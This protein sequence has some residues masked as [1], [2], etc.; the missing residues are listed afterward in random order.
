MHD[1]GLAGLRRC[2]GADDGVG[3]CKPEAVVVILVPC[4]LAVVGL[5]A[6]VTKLTASI[7][8]ATGKRQKR[9]AVLMGFL[10]TIT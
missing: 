9:E 3:D 8:A 4:A 1:A 6:P 10:G 5:S 2:A 7:A